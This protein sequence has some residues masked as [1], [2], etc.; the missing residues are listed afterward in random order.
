MTFLP[1]PVQSPRI[2]IWVIGAWPRMPSLRRALRW[3]G[4]LPIKI[5]EDGSF[6]Q[7]TPADIQ[8][9]KAL[10][11]DH[12]LPSPP[13]D[14]VLEGETPGNDLSRTVEIVRPFAQ[15]GVTWWLEDLWTT[16]ETQGGVEGMRGRIQQGPP[17][18]D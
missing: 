3:D 13:F 5:Q 16:H 10:L 8:D 6:A 12:H 18:F 15:A 4:I 14:I 9:L 2:P 11:E 17:R 7:M 1:P